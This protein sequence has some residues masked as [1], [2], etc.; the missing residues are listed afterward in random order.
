MA[1]DIIRAA[2]AADITVVGGDVVDYEFPAVP[3]VVFL[4]NPFGADTLRATVANLERS[5]KQ[6]PRQMFVAY[7]NAVH[8]D[9]LDDSPALR[10]VARTRHG[11]VYEAL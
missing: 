3:A 11:A 6:T 1:R 10:L 9:V 7:F 5:L 8:R 4:F 2:G